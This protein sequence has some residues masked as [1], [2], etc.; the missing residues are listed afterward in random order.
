MEFLF[1]VCDLKK[2]KKL[3]LIEELLLVSS[4]FFN[5][6]NDFL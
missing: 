1:N 6:L 3:P 2:C 4:L 5:Y